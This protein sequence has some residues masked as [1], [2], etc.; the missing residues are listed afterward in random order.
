MKCDSS[1]YFKEIHTI[2]K[3]EFPITRLTKTWRNCWVYIA[4]QVIGLLN[5]SLRCQNKINSFEMTYYW[6]RIVLKSVKIS[7]LRLSSS[8]LQCLLQWLRHILWNE[9][10]FLY[11]LLNEV[12]HSLFP[13]LIGTCLV[14][15][16]FSVNGRKN[17]QPFE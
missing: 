10:Q 3:T 4:T 6:L 14:V 15:Q 17:G 16:L 13:S 9:T 8:C 5:I 2:G 11:D 1:D 12:W 7:S